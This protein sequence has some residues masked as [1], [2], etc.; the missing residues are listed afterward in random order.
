MYGLKQATVLTY[1]NL[2]TNLKDFGYSPGK[3]IT[4]IWTHKTRRTTFCLYVDDFGVKFFNKSDADHLLSSLQ[5][6]Y[7][8]TVDWS[9]EIFC[10]LT[11]VWNYNKEYADISMPKYIPEILSRFKYKQPS[12]LQFSPHQHVPIKFG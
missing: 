1:K 2:I 10:G 7:E 8:Y 6:N 11:I 9:G 4:G 3:N 12:K 5:Q